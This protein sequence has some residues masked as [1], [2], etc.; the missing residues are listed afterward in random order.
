MRRRRLAMLAF[1]CG[2]SLGLGSAVAVTEWRERKAESLVT[3]AVIAASVDAVEAEDGMADR[4]AGLFC[5]ANP[6]LDPESARYYAYAVLEASD[7]YGL[8]E[9][10][11]AGLV[12]TE[13]RADSRA[14]N[15]NCLGLTQVNWPVWAKELEEKHPEI[16]G[17]ADL[18][19][20]RKSILA[21]AW[22][23]RHYLDRHGDLRK[24]LKAYSGGAA[25]YPGKVLRVAEG[26]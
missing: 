3:A 25:W 5:E 6:K 12:Y 26:L 7:R 8:P 20:P 1:L 13:S 2:V 23:L 14:R 15:G 11:L 24:A 21:G 17:K 22:I 4:I 18:F 19:E 16:Y 10:V 9:A